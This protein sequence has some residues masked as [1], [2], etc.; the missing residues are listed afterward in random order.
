[1]ASSL[2]QLNLFSPILQLGIVNRDHLDLSVVMKVDAKSEWIESG[3]TDCARLSSSYKNL[4]FVIWNQQIDKV[5]LHTQIMITIWSSNEKY[6]QFEARHSSD[7]I[8]TELE[9]INAIKE[10]DILRISKSAFW[11]IKHDYFHAKHSISKVLQSNRINYSCIKLIVKEFT[12]IRR[13]LWK[14]QTQ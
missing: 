11:K 9:L 5:Q 2:S 14:L 6:F 8:I 12:K 1:M 13:K 3:L 4:V 7:V 10:L